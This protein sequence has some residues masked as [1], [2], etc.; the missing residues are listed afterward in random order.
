MKKVLMLSLLLFAA[1]GP[2]AAADDFKRFEFHP[3]GGFTA[4][5]SIPLVTDDDAHHESVHVNSSY[6]VGAAFAVNLNALDAVE[7][8][9]QRQF[10]GGRLPAEIAAPLS[11]G[12]SPAFDL[13]IDQ[14]HLNFLH[15][16]QIADP[17]AMPYV[18]AGL[19][20]T[21]YHASRSGMSDSRSYF[22]FSIGGG[23]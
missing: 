3:F 15:H 11:S 17:R 18:M 9:W 4:S 6:N 2:A 22:S 5:G 12:G 21:T 20:A 1:T 16:Y 23:M 14:F 7:A 8:F 19:G 13:K 10:T